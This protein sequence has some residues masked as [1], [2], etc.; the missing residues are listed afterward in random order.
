MIETNL[1]DFKSLALDPSPGRKN[2]LLKGVA[3]LFAFTSE[4]CTMEQI[5]IYDDVI[6]RLADMVEAEAKIFAAEKIAPLRRAP[7]RTVRK[8]AA[9]DMIEVAGPV[10]KRSPVLNDHDLVAIAEKKGHG[11]L[12][13][14]AQRSVL[15][16][17]VTDVVV[18]HGNSDVRRTVASNHGARLG[19]RA[20]AQIVQQALSDVRMAE[21]LGKRPDTPDTVIAQVVGQ[22]VTSVRAAIGSEAESAMEAQLNEAAKMAEARMSN[23][24]WLGLYDFETAWEK[25]LHQGGRRIASEALMCQYALEDRFA[26]VVATFALVADLDLEEAKHWLVRMDTEPFV[27]MAKALGMK[28]TTVQ[29]MLKAGPWKHRLDGEQRMQALN[30]FQQIDPRVARSRIAATRG[31]RLVG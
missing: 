8:F 26:D 17:R 24:Y 20:L 12:L 22:A 11:H 25:I 29:A 30:Q 13:A 10:L 2:E 9:D 5:E 1:V 19:E 6:G 4:R 28:F 21:I 27:V 7:E 18:G 3:S 16:E 31:Q 14:I 15:S 23:S